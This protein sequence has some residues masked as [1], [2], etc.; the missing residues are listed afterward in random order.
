M[1]EVTVGV[2]G[3]RDGDGGTSDR[4]CLTALT[5]RFSTGSDMSTFCF[6]W[7]LLCSNLNHFALE[8]YI[9]VHP[10]IRIRSWVWSEPYC[11]I[12]LNLADCL[13]RPGSPPL[14]PPFP[15]LPRENTIDRTHPEPLVCS[16]DNQLWIFVAYRCLFVKEPFLS[17]TQA[18]PPVPCGLAQNGVGFS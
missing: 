4:V 1:E 14:C 16:F 11:C 3:G 2:G 18:L 13:D 9:C 8:K 15:L 7:A 17:P 12:C 10:K 5:S 6:G